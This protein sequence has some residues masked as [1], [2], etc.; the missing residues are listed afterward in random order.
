MMI[1]TQGHIVYA[2]AHA[3]KRNDDDDEKCFALS[4]LSFEITQHVSHNTLGRS[5]LDDG[6]TPVDS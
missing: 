5:E 1:G 6:N 3:F 2:L 4:F